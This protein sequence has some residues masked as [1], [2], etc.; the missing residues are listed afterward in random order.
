MYINIDSYGNNIA[1]AVQI[2]P[3]LRRKNKCIV[4]M[5]G[6]DRILYFP[7]LTRVE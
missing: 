2:G 1:K 3:H 5:H 6:R 4:A 7:L